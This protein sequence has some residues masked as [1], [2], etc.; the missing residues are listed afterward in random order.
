M[1]NI[2]NLIV[3]VKEYKET[4]NGKTYIS[5]YCKENYKEQNSPFMNFKIYVEDT[6]F[7]DRQLIKI[8]EAGLKVETWLNSTNDVKVTY[9]LFCK[10]ENIAIVESTKSSCKKDYSKVSDDDI[11]F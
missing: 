10:K 4:K 1:L 8:K 5:A 6:E 11:P 3:T 7:D 9:V 2:T